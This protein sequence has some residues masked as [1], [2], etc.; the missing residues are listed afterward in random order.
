MSRPE[1]GILD[2]KWMA[3]RRARIGKP[4]MNCKAHKG[5]GRTILVSK[6][7]MYSLV[8]VECPQCLRAQEMSNNMPPLVK[9]VEST[10][11]QPGSN[12]KS[13][14]HGR[15]GVS[16]ASD[17][18]SPWELE[19]FVVQKRKKRN[20]F[21]SILE[22][23]VRHRNIQGPV[24]GRNTE[25]RNTDLLIILQKIRGKSQARRCYYCGF[26]RAEKF[27][28]QTMLTCAKA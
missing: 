17:H 4:I 3:Q 14:W 13:S 8:I 18:H 9:E 2:S 26:R 11:S 6:C 19:R 7:I 28:T 12:Q 23:E 22:S 1:K 24:I 27:H 20:E 5:L 15:I 25:V 16:Q 21:R 10:W